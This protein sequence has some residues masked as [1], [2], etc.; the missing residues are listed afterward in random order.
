MTTD[1]FT[2]EQ[3]LEQPNGLFDE[4]MNEVFKA[5]KGNENAEN[6]LRMAF[7]AGWLAS[8]SQQKHSQA[9]LVDLYIRAFRNDALARSA[10]QTETKQ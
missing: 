8:A 10:M 6:A 5:Y 7:Q 3:V 2:D 1:N 9:T 4:M